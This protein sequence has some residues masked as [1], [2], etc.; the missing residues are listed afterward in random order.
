MS[1]EEK[2]AAMLNIF[3]EMKE[4]FT[5]K[6]LEKLGTKAG[7]VTQTIKD[8]VQSLIDDNMVELE[9]IGASNY[10]WSFPSKTLCLKRN[11]IDAARAG[12]TAAEKSITDLE[13][14]IA[15]LSAGRSDS[16]DRL[17]RLNRLAELEAESVKLA[18]QIAVHKENDPEILKV[19]EKKLRIAKQAADR[20]TDNVWTLKTFAVREMGGDP[21]EFDRALEIGDSFDYV[22]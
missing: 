21:S 5:L 20:W 18:S 19:L 6:E 7:V 9:K 13:F 17:A 4:A 15:S 2:R 16:D 10:Y 3:H 1:L 12:V 8:V 11:R 22:A 14:T